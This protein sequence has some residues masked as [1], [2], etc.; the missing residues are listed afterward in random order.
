MSDI[1]KELLLN[2]RGQLHGTGDTV[3]MHGIMLQR[4]SDGIMIY[5]SADYY[6]PV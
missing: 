4:S 6:I 5:E 2:R 3:N 1:T